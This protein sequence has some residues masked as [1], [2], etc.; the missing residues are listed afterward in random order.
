[1]PLLY[2]EHL[3]Y[4]Y[5]MC[6]FLVPKLLL[7]NT[8]A[9]KLQLPVSK[10]V[11]AGA[12]TTIKAFPSWSLGTRRLVKGN[13]KKLHMALY[14]LSAGV[15]NPQGAAQADFS[16]VP[17]LGLGNKKVAQRIEEAFPIQM[18]LLRNRCLG[19]IA[20]ER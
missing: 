10:R 6:N 11:E 3:P 7:G 16:F 18:A 12:S 2:S 20:S 9:R 19:Y 4:T 13:I 15:A 5:A 1:M 8:L 17:K 14:M